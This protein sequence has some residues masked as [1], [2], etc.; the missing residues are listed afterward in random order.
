MLKCYS[1][2]AA[3][4][5]NRQLPGDHGEG[6]E[7]GLV[8]IHAANPSTS[9]RIIAAQPGQPALPNGADYESQNPT[10]KHGAPAAATH[11]TSLSPPHMATRAPQ[12]LDSAHDPSIEGSHPTPP[13]PIRSRHRWSHDDRLRSASKPPGTQHPGGFFASS[14]TLSILSV[15]SRS[16]RRAE[17]HH[18]PPAGQGW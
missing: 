10:R 2:W 8:H 7:H 4:S 11:T 3:P 1:E 5:A 16:P 17:A 9:P 15:Q 12:R 6:S 13:K 14:R 18:H